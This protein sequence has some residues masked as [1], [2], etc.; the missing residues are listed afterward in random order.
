MQAPI[1][2]MGKWSDATLNRN[3][4]RS[5]LMFDHFDAIKHEFNHSMI[6]MVNIFTVFELY[7]GSSKCISLFW[8]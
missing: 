3:R 5:L 8:T 7:K 4:W 2:Q 6:D 1:L